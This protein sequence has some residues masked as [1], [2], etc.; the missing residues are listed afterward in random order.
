MSRQDLVEAINQVRFERFDRVLHQVL[1]E[2][3]DG[4]PDGGDASDVTPLKE[5]VTYNLGQVTFHARFLCFVFT[6]EIYHYQALDGVD[7]SAV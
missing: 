2:A 4:P 1:V 5:W 3:G 7:I 6:A